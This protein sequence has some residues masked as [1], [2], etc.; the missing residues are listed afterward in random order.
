MQVEADYAPLYA[1]KGL[2]L[3]IWSPLAS[4]LLTG[5]YSKDHVPPDRCTWIQ[6][7]PVA[8]PCYASWL[9]GAWDARAPSVPC[10]PTLVAMHGMYMG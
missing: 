2:G 1:S 5:K 10:S 3:T 8:R 6:Q 7:G 4:G 9:A